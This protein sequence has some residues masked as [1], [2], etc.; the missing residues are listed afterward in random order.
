MP[1]GD[2]FITP[3]MISRYTYSADV[4]C[5]QRVSLQAYANYNAI[6]VNGKH[7]GTSSL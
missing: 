6:D 5:E 3:T 7:I 1:A 4:N 2:I